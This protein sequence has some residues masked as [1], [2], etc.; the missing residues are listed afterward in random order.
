M[1]C[2]TQMV[3]YHI[4]WREIHRS[5]MMMEVLFFFLETGAQISA[6]HGSQRFHTIK[7]RQSA[8]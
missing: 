3:S 2:A 8:K 1:L 4:K 6:I 5:S 7:K